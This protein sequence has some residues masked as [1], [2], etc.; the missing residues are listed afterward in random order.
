MQFG[1][2][3]GLCGGSVL[4]IRSVLTAAHCPIGSSSTLVIAGAHNR[5]LSLNQ[6]NNVV[7]YRYPH[8]PTPNFAF[9]AHVQAARMP[10]AFASE[11]FVGETARSTGW[12]RTTN[13]GATSAVL[14]R[15]TIQSLLTLLAQL[16][17]VDQL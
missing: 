17:M 8:P 4:T 6:I 7:L 16:S 14:R 12:G 3:T 2:G 9:G 1:T 13:T 15:L 11:L 5:K 10:T